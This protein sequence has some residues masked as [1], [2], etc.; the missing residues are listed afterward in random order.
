MAQLTGR[1]VLI[2]GAASGI[3]AAA[4]RRLVADGAR[5]VLADLD[6]A[7][8]EKVAGE[9]GQVAVKADVTRSDDIER[10]VEEVYRRWGRLDVLFN[11][12]GVIRVQPMLDVT[13]E[14]WDRVM[15]VNLRAAFFVLQAAARRMV[16]Q[17][18]MPGSDLRG[19]L[20]HTASIAAFR[21]GN[22]MMTPYSASKTGVVSLTRSAA[23]ALA[24]Q[25]I[26]SNCVCPGAVE[27]PMWEQIDREWGALEGVGEGEMWKRR[28]RGIPLG[29][30]ERPE[31]VAN[32]IAFLAGPDSDYMT[33]Q[34]L[35]VDGGM[36]MGN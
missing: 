1:T 17:E 2:T 29:R 7:K 9:L 31:D 35:I 30:P 25:R 14:E 11:N 32:V 24:P 28:I 6:G 19:K 21:G 15:S 20:I 10:M 34:A 12:A 22:H 8:V 23:Q 18:L 13:G 33:G 4:A 5:L 3:G 36:V 16:R 27:T 26:T